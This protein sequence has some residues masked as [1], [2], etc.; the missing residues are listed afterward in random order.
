MKL[1]IAVPEVGNVS[2]APARFVR[3]A[4]GWSRISPGRSEEPQ[5]AFRWF[6][7][8]ARSLRF[9]AN[10][11]QVIE[12]YVHPFPTHVLPQLRE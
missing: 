8:V 7:P 3:T 2:E 5:T 9:P 4:S 11:F 1:A 10:R 6:V 12:H